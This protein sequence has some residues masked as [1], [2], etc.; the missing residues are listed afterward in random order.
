MFG[1]DISTE[2]EI[3][4]G[5]QRLTTITILFSALA[6]A[7]GDFDEPGLADGVYNYVEGRDA[8]NQPFF[9]IKNE[10]PK[11]FFQCRIQ[12]KEKLGR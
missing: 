7:F 12:H 9:R 5:Q 2:F 4:D 10:T 3:V 11:P 1:S 8:S 6:Q